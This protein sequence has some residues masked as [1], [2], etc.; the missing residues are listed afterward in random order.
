[1]LHTKSTLLDTAKRNLRLRN[2]PRI[3][4]HHT[5]LQRLRNPP[6]PPNIPREEISRES[7]IRVVSQL[8]HLLLGL[9]L[10]QSSERAEGLFGV[11]QGGGGDVGEDCGCEEGARAGEFRAAD[12]DLRAFGDGVVDVRLDL[13]DGAVVNQGA[14]CSVRWYEV[15]EQEGKKIIN[16]V[17]GGSI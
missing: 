5:H 14:V 16:V 11:E 8:D 1:M 7:V 2:H 13:F 17:I 4:T 15:S 3:R 6:H 10:N 9:E 12:E